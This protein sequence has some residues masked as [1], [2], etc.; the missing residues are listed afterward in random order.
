MN[1]LFAI[2]MAAQATPSAMSVSIDRV[3]W[4]HG[5]WEQ[6]GAQRI[7]EEQWMAPRGGSMLGMSRTVRDGKLLE[8]ESVTIREDAGVLVYDARPSGQPPASF[9]AK[10]VSNDAV[11]FENLQHD[12]PQRVGYRRN[13]PDQITA[14]VEGTSNGKPRRTEFPYRRARCGP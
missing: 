10:D 5:C 3:A 14:W 13:G 9:R 12:F 2:W 1:A 6:V 8:Y 11:V 7:V 4:L